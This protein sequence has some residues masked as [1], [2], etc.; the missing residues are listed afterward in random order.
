MVSTGL[1]TRQAMQAFSGV[2]ADADPQGAIVASRQHKTMAVNM[3]MA[4]QGPQL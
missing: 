2:W 1:A 4:I 3:I